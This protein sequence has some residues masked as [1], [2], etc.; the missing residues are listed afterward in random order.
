MDGKQISSE[1]IYRGQVV[2]L[3]L[4]RVALSSG[5]TVTME[6]IHHP[7]AAAVVALDADGD[8]VLVDQYRYATG[9]RMLEVPAGKLDA[10]ETPEI[11]AAREL[12]EEAGFRCARL[13]SLGWIWTTPGFTNEKI[14]L[15]LAR[16]LERSAAAPEADELLEVVRMPFGDAVAAA[17]DGRI[18]DGK[19]ICALL[20]ARA[21]I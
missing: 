6:L 20:R 13:E 21:L 12:A 9:G 10:G 1:A 3:T 7:G 14:W 19:S 16:D 5:A 15:F 2:D 4:E 8:V 18:N 17:F 11:C